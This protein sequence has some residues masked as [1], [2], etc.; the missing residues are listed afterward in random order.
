M[1]TDSC[2]A[3]YNMTVIEHDM[4]DWSPGVGGVGTPYLKWRGWSNE[5]KNQQKSVD[6]KFIARKSHA[7]L[8]SL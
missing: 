5:G 8:Q 6:Q 3:I 7:K 1:Q 4:G 2:V